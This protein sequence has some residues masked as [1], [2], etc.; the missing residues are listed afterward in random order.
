M[1]DASPGRA[2]AWEGREGREGME[3]GR[4]LERRPLVFEAV[5]I[6]PKGHF[7]G[8]EQQRVAQAYDRRHLPKVFQGARHVRVVDDE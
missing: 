6:F 3:E 8:E 5:V 2:L 7:L 4:V 1:T